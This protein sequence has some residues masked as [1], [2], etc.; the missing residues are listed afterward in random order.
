MAYTVVFTPEA[1]AQLTELYGYID[2]EASPEIAARFQAQRPDRTLLWEI[3][4]LCS[5]PEDIFRIDRLWA[6]RHIV[7]GPK[8]ICEVCWINDRPA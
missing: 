4:T 2:T 8:Q 1:E 5:A 3:S 7:H 6:F